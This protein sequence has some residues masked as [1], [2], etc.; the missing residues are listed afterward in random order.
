MINYVGIIQINFCYLECSN[1]H[2]GAY[3]NIFRKSAVLISEAGNN[4]V[5]LSI[6]NKEGNAG[7]Q[8]LSIN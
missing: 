2:C 4:T 8:N 5:H 7:V 6:L 1:N 3:H